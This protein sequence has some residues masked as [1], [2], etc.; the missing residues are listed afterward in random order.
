[1]VNLVL[2]SSTGST[3]FPQT[4][5]VLPLRPIKSRQ[6]NNHGLIRS[7]GR[8]KSLAAYGVYSDLLISSVNGINSSSP[9][10][11]RAPKG[12]KYLTCQPRACRRHQ[13][14]MERAKIPK[15]EYHII[16]VYVYLEA[17]NCL[18]LLF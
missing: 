4:S 9:T 10:T 14:D 5:L 12:Q 6:C 16:T 17:P 15:F 3:L 2:R 7:K 8:Q 11:I 13:P 1:M 18:C